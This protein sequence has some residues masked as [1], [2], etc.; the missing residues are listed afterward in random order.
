M[1]EEGKRGRKEQRER[2]TYPRGG[3]S[4]SRDRVRGECRTCPTTTTT[5]CV[6]GTVSVQRRR[7]PS[8][9]HVE[10]E[11]SAHSE[12]V[13]VNR[14]RVSS[15]VNKPLLPTAPTVAARI[16]TDRGTSASPAA[17]ESPRES[18]PREDSAAPGGS[19][20]TSPRHAAKHRL[21]FFAHYRTMRGARWCVL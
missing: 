16:L 18:P 2:E 3:N 20:H 17:P 11:R 14:R 12:T 4:G 5:T 9:S 13:S 15:P 7:Y 1:R 6:V 10:A 8:T 21:R 19:R